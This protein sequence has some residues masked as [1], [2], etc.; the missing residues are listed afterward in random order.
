MTS[1]QAIVMAILQGVTELFP[2]SSLGHA[3]ILPA[4]L[5]W[6]IDQN[7]EGFLP[8]L[9][10]MHLGTALALLVYFWRAGAAS[11]SACSTS[12]TAPERRIGAFSGGW[13]WRPS[14]R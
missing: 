1:L 8:F 3:V 13:S 10:V 4:L 5:H 6:N 12:A 7:A 9:A 11:A 14:R 2:I